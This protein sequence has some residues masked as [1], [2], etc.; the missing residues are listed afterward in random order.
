M[1]IRLAVPSEAEQ[2]WFIRNNAI[3]HSCKQSF[4]HSVIMAW[5]PDKMP[6][7]YRTMVEENP[8][9]VVVNELNIPIAT[10]FL[11]L[12]QHSVDAIFTLPEYSGLGAAR[13]IMD[14]IKQ[15]AKSR[16]IKQLTLEST[17]NAE[18]FYQKQGFISQN[19]GQYY[20]ALAQSY[21]PCINMTLSL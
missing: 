2:L 4:S 15:E 8:F 16:H 9:F 10:G 12:K 14:R 18:R 20:S 19:K 11:N 21:L 6:E 17:P 5:T 1:E 7:S 13:L 3:R